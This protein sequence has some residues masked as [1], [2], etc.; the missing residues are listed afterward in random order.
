VRFQITVHPRSRANEVTPDPEQGV[1]RVRV[2][3]PP[4]DGKANEAVLALLKERLGLRAGALRLVGG[5][6]SRRKWIEVDGLTEE[7]LWRR[8]KAGL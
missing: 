6:S 1:V 8:L 4:A 5:A 7:E 2:T 3:A